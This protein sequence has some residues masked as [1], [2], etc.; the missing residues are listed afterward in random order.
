MSRASTPSEF[1]S[2]LGAALAA[3]RRRRGLTQEEV[4]QRCEV[5][6]SYIARV[7]RGQR[8]PSPLVL[9]RLLRSL[10]LT[11][12]EVWPPPRAA[13]QVPRYGR[14]VGKREA[15]VARLLRVTEH[16]SPGDITQLALLVRRLTRGRRRPSGPQEEA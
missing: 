13:E 14:T 1:G 8:L 9:D 2:S 10:E 16:L 15:A 6:T 5:S 11:A 12:G 4:A 7:E 3:G